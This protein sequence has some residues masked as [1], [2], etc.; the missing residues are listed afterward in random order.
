MAKEMNIIDRIETVRANSV[1]DEE[2]R[3]F[4][5][6]SLEEDVKHLMDFVSEFD[7]RMESGKAE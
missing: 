7:A 4:W 2:Y 5:G 1:T 3:A 6:T